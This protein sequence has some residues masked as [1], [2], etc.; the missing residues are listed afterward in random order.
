MKSTTRHLLFPRVKKNLLLRPIERLDQERDIQ[1]FRDLVQSPIS[2]KVIVH[3]GPPHSITTLPYVFLSLSRLNEDE[4]ST[5]L[6]G[7][8]LSEFLYHRK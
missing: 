4:D 7:M 1:A 8:P 5:L 2:I 3:V 6:E